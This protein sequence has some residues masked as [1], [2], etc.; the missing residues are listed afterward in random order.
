M[1]DYR[2]WLSAVAIGLT[3]AALAP[4]LLSVLRGSVRPHVFS[5]V[6]WAIATFIVFLAQ[7]ADGGGVGA[8]PI[9]VSGSITL[10]IALVAFAKRAD[11]SITRLDWVFF[12]AALTAVPLWFLTSDP[13]WAVVILTIVDLLGFGPTLGKAWRSPWTESMGFFSL[14]ALRN[15]IVIGAL[16]NYSMTTVLFPAVI[17]TACVG[18]VAVGLVR[19]RGVAA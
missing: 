19:R 1:T 3:F 10:V 18:V 9:G 15:Y 5:W 6:I 2:P 4:Y 12:I 13:L 7:L 17:G 11:I 8:W 16:E 14:L